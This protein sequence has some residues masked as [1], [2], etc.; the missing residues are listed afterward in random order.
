MIGSLKLIQ[1]KHGFR[2]GTDAVLLADFAKD[3]PSEKTLDL[4]TGSGIVPILL[5]HKSDAK[6]IYGLEIQEDIHEMSTRSVKLNSLEDKVELLKG[7]LK[8]ILDFFPKRTFSL[9]TAN[10]PYMKGG[11]GISS[12]DYSKHVSRH[13]ALCTLEDVISSAEKMLSLGGHFV[14]VHRPSRLTDIMYLMRKYE[15]E[16]KRLRFVLPKENA[17]PSLVLIDGLFKGGSELKILPPLIL[18]D[19][20]GSETDELK[21]IYERR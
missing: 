3:I 7:D 15:I 8:N 11:S 6:K 5:S 18:Y 14:M 4:C 17:V 21:E 12:A 19:E 9:V 2:F 10:P 13:E 1:K 16:P 20:N